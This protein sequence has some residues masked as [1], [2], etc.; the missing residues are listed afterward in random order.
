MAFSAEAGYKQESDKKYK[1]QIHIYTRK[2]TKIYNTQIHRFKTHKYTD[3]QHTNRYKEIK[4]E[5]C[6]CSI[7]CR[8]WVAPHKHKLQLSAEAGGYENTNTEAG[9]YQNTNTE[10]VVYENTNTKAGRYQITNTEA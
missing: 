7:W 2:N 6:Q 1:T 10:A 3:L 9:G 4:G 5:V 8:T